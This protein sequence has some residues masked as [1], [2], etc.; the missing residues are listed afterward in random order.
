MNNRYS[1]LYLNNEKKQVSRFDKSRSIKNK[2]NFERKT[3][4]QY[5]PQKSRLQNNWRSFEND[6]SYRHE[7]RS[8]D[9][10]GHIDYV[11]IYFYPIFNDRSN[12][13]QS[14][15]YKFRN[16]YG[17]VPVSFQS[18]NKTVLF[19]IDDES[20]F[21]VFKTHL[22]LFYESEPSSD[23]HG[24]EYALIIN[25][26][27]FE[28]LTSKRIKKWL[29]SENIYLELFDSA[30]IAISKMHILNSLKEYLKKNE[31]IFS[32]PE[33]NII[34]L[35]QADTATLESIIDNFDIIHQAYSYKYKTKRPGEF[36]ESRTVTPFDL[37]VSDDLP[38]V[39]VL[40]TG[41][42]KHS[43]INEAVENLGIDLTNPKNPLP[44]LD[45]EGHGTA[46]AG[47]IVVGQDYYK[48]QK[49]EYNAAAKV[50]PV[51]ILRER[52]GLFSLLEIEH[53]IRFL[54]TEH[55]IRIFNLSV[56]DS[57]PKDYNEPISK[58]AYLL[59]KLSYEL[60]ILIFI[61]TGNLDFDDIK[62]YFKEPDD[63]VYYPTH[64]Y[65]PYNENGL[66]FCS[67]SNLHTPAESMNNLTV[68]AIADNFEN[69][70][71]LTL[72]KSLPAYYT[73][74]HH[75]DFAQKINNVEVP[76][77]IRNRN[78][79]KP[80]ISFY[81]GDAIDNR[82]G[83]LIFSND[84]TKL[85]TRS[86]GTSLATPF[87]SNLAAK[88]VRA[89]PKINMQT[90]KA[91]IIN[92][93]VKGNSSFLDEL[94]DELK[95]EESQNRY[96]KS[97]NNLN[98]RKEKKEISALFNKDNLYNRLAG[99][100]V[101]NE[102]SCLYS[103]ENEVVFVIEDVIKADTQQITTI[104]L[105]EYLQGKDK[106]Q[107]LSVSA[108]LCYKFNPVFENQLAYNPLHIAFKFTKQLDDDVE[109][110]LNISV[111]NQ[112]SYYSQFYEKSMDHKDK[113]KV[114]NKIRG[115]KASDFSW[116]EDF[117]PVNNR[118]LSNVQKKTFN[119]QK[120]D[121]VKADNTIALLIRATL[122]DEA[123]DPEFLNSIEAKQNKFSLVI[124]IT[125]KDPDN[126]NSLIDKLININTCSNIVELDTELDIENTI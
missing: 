43:A 58:Y 124:S 9:I 34:E 111:D 18:F 12:N 87:A 100:G 91:L 4:E 68:G 13:N 65:N 75:Y 42:Q 81:G 32:F 76:R 64:F 54:Y 24:T 47:I 36:S 52:E 61:A 118:L 20:K 33:P 114:R 92:S 49:T 88:I 106:D 30:E 38:K 60:D 3:P 120:K 104:K 41:I 102:N 45:D 56:V 23:P 27:E 103:S 72:D 53:T 35:K 113:L 25:I 123:I 16:Q 116:S 39:A 26:H 62:I 99:H 78:L 86:C 1:H 2:E 14:L 115:I 10:P 70:T 17:L 79:F 122:K 37:I 105:P 101:P 110:S 109:E 40:D 15:I 125:E 98:A 22:K 8:I 31:I 82:S 11:K 95:E 69:I 107:V 83:L 19:A 59:D 55:N 126:E 90:V 28:F 73:L 74:K 5:Q 46:V 119:L 7:K 71:D 89:Y 121:L 85:T 51:K 67:L 66:H 48:N 44:I 63:T 112:H 57:S 29:A 50:I 94:F 93:A 96:G 77:S 6:I 97:F 84:M 80:D 21:K 117:F 108:T